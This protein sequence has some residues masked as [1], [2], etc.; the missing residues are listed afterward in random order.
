MQEEKQSGKVMSRNDDDAMTTTAYKETW[1]ET[2]RPRRRA[3]KCK[4]GPM[5]DRQEFW[6]VTNRPKRSRKAKKVAKEASDLPAKSVDNEM[7]ND[8]KENVMT[9]EEAKEKADLERDEEFE[10]CKKNDDF[11][12]VL[13]QLNKLPDDTKSMNKSN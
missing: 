4:E 1:P 12:N 11:S 3:K 10:I 7:R 13:D 6:L 8:I 9:S 5:H 2:S